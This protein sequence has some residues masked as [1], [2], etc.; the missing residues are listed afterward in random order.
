MHRRKRTKEKVVCLEM[1][2]ISENV[3]ISF[4]GTSL[5]VGHD[6]IS[7]YITDSQHFV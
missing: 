6:G 5:F 7:R 4:T 2:N 1:I 3:N